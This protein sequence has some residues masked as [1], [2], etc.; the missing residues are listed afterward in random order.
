MDIAKL[1]SRYEYADARMESVAE[2]SIG[3]TD[4]EL[5]VSSGKSRGISARVLIGNSWGFASSNRGSE[6]LETLLARAEKL[7]K[8]EKGNV[9]IR[10]PGLTKKK[11][12][13]KSAYVGSE[14]KI[15]TLKDAAK[16][17]GGKNIIGKQARYI[18]STIEKEFYSSEGSEIFQKTSYS[19]LNFTAIAKEGEIIQRGSERESSIKGFKKI[20]TYENATEA[21]EKA[22]RML[23]AAPAP[24]GRLTV[25]MDSEMTGVFSHEAL[26]HATEADSVIDRESILQGKLGMKIGS[27]LVTITDEP[28]AEDFGYYAYDDEGVKSRKTELIVNG[29]LKNYLHSM[30]TAEKLDLVLNGHA[31]AQSYGSFPIVR[32]GNTYFMPGKASVD[33]VFDARHAVYVKGMKGGSVDIFSGGFMFKAEE[34]YEIVNGEKKKLLR[35]VTLSGNILETLNNVEI[36]GKDFATSPGFCGKFGQSVPVSDGGPHIRVG[37]VMVG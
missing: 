33:D 6:S 34:G 11:T 29:V 12:E 8:I 1:L 20:K 10:A 24:K 35:D 21:K 37:S 16:N 5:K 25:I 28:E 18:E 27:E 3:I 36:I 32:M 4:E 26:G 13:M 23:T 22:Q 7:A 19:Y 14:E 31:R 15:S 30:E 17:M 2:E 9:R